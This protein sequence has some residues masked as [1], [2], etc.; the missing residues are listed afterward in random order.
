VAFFTC[1]YRPLVNGLSLAVERLAAG[2]RARGHRVLIVAPRYPG[3]PAAET[4]CLRLPSL[5]VPTHHAYAVPL[6]W[7]AGGRR[8]VAA[9]RPAIVHAHHP[10]LVG[11][12]AARLARRLGVPFVFTHHT[13]YEHY[14]HY[15]P[16]AAALAGAIARRRAARFAARAD[17]VVVP[18]PGVARR[19]A[20]EGV[21]APIVTIPTGVMASSPGA[22]ESRAALRRDLLRGAAGPLL[23]AV[24]RLAPEKNLEALLRAF[25]LAAADAPGAALCLVGDGDDRAR[26]ARRAAALGVA[27]RVRFVGPVAPEAVGGYYAAAD[28]F[29]FPSLSEA[30]GLVVLEALA[31]G[32]PVLAARSPAVEDLLADGVTA[33]LVEPTPEGLAA[34]LRELL[35]SP[36]LRARLGRAGRAL[37]AAHPFDA[38]VDRHVQAYRELLRAHPACGSNLSRRDATGTA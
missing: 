38:S 30:Q 34:G 6:P 17:L 28:V 3:A 11:P 35:A 25:A 16:G 27:G 4:D 18:S 29:A 31:H 32:L 2:L 12:Y 33:R 8:A 5:R 7:L 36:D 13:L 22:G 10:F 23:L 15:V 24:G 1:N 19:L 14:R 37:A 9:A 26:L 21:R 20:A